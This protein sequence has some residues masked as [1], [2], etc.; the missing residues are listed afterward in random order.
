MRSVVTPRHLF[1]GVFFLGTAFL[2]SLVPV[3]GG[4]TWWYLA[5]GRFIAETGGVP[6][7]DPFSF[8][9]PG[10]PW[11]NPE[12]LTY[13]F[14]FL[15]YR[16]GGFEALFA[17]KVLLTGMLL[18]L[19]FFR[20]RKRCASDGGALLGV[21]LLALGISGYIDIR[22]QLFTF[23]LTLLA[24]FVLETSRP[25]F[26]QV[27][28]IAA[29]T[30]LWANLHGGFALMFLWGGIHF[31]AACF[32]GPSPLGKSSPGRALILL[33]A[34]FGGSLL[35]PYGLSL[36]HNTLPYLLMLLGALVGS[37]Q[38]AL[39]QTLEWISPL[40][41]DVPGFTTPLFWIA[42]GFL[43]WRLV[44]RRHEFSRFDLLRGLAL[45]G[46]ALAS[47]RFIPLFFLAAGDLFAP[48]TSGEAAPAK[49]PRAFPAA[50]WGLLALLLLFLGVRAVPD[51][52]SSLTRGF[53]YHTTIQEAFPDAA[54]NFLRAQ[55]LSGRI[56][57]DYNWGGF[58]LWQLF[59]P[60]TVFVD[61]RIQ[62]VYPPEILLERQALEAGQNWEEICRRRNVEIMVL[63]PH[64][65]GHL[66]RLANASGNWRILF[67]DALS[68]VLI[69]RD[70]EKNIIP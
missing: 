32:P 26:L 16:A 23:L 57:N 35:T 6:A 3:G 52:R 53:F 27:L 34:A 54:C 40:R 22:A 33:G 36:Y 17:L 12:W 51:F 44:L 58:L 14:F 21:T 55:G 7:G 70:L 65:E 66:V 41:T 46:M 24:Y 43:A 30:A 39:P 29:I 25:F 18:G 68:V 63:S 1:L 59:P 64:L 49:A 60:S 45:G 9:A 47:R 48:G 38:W 37:A 56:F 42:L 28:G 31:V 13:L 50:E 15:V 2:V 61:G 62:T 10:A 11:V 4:D 20:L 8:T 69:R 5:T 19:A 67:E